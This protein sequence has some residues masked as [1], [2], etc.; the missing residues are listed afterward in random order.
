MAS[1]RRYYAKTQNFRAIENP[2]YEYADQQQPYLSTAFPPAAQGGTYII[3]S[4]LSSQSAPAPTRQA[5]PLQP[6]R[7]LKGVPIG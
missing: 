3:P 6:R 7:L 2:G 4:L 1:C 5:A